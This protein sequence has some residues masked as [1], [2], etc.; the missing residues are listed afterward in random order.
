M[1]LLV[2]LRKDW[3][4]VKQ[5]SMQQIFDQCPA[6]QP[7]TV[8]EGPNGEL[9]LGQ[10]AKTEQCSDEYHRWEKQELR[11]IAEFAHFHEN[12]SSIICR[13]LRAVSG[14]RRTQYNSEVVF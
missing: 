13:R 11:K 7:G 3:R 14:Y 6:Y 4:V 2:Y 1:V 12:T 10:A 5:Y 9:R 8:D